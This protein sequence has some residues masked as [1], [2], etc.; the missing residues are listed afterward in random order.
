M[1]ACCHWHLHQQ[2]HDRLHLWSQAQPPAVFSPPLQQAVYGWLDRA[3]LAQQLQPEQYGRYHRRLHH[4][5]Q[6]QGQSRQPEQRAVPSRSSPLQ[7]YRHG[8]LRLQR[9][10][11]RR[12]AMVQT[13]TMNLLTAPPP[14]RLML[15][16]KTPLC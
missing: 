1:P 10:Q 5:Q 12:G 13:R 11:Y 15:K 8:W 2:P 3:P 14:E 16:M 7:E 6:P 9:R 4:P